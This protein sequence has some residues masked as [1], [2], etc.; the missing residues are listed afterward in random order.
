MSPGRFFQ[1][2]LPV[3]RPAKSL[4]LP[5]IMFIKRTKMPKVYTFLLCFLCLNGFSQNTILWEVKDT[6]H[7]KTSYLL[8]TYHQLGNH[9]AD[10]HPVIAE[11]LLGSEV[12]IFESLSEVD[13]TPTI[14]ARPASEAFK[15]ELGRK[16]ASQL[17]ELAKNWKYPPEKLRPEEI[18]FKLY[19]SYYQTHCG[20]I[21][22]T[23][24]FDHFDQYLLHLARINNLAT[25]GLETDSMQIEAI[26]KNIGA[27]GWKALKKDILFW[28]D[29]HLGK[30]DE[31]RLCAFTYRYKQFD[32]DYAFG[33][34]C[35]PDELITVRNDAWMAI[36]PEKMRTQN[37]FVA[38]GLLHLYHDCGL[39]E[40]LRKLGFQV[41]E[42]QMK[43]GG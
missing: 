8:G 21:L 39:I 23:D 19:Q 9:F 35:P 11:K 15:K 36:L 40:Q 27:G 7:H 38:V 20:N 26:N 1:K 24:A 22:A 14:L 33:Q 42:V 41:N 5:I 37:C 30:K 34:P 29:A 13:V 10:G 18:V 31:E 25:F 28:I 12:A 6:L 43:S 3:Y 32:L 4:L 2:W 17:I 16:S